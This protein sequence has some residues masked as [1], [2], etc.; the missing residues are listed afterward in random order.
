MKPILIAAAMMLG[1]M[2]LAV[3]QQKSDGEEK[4][5]VKS[6]T[7]LVQYLVTSRKGSNEEEVLRALDQGCA[8]AMVQRNL[9]VLE[10]IEADEFTFTTPD[11]TIMT[12]AQD[13]ETIRSGDIVYDSLTLEDVKVKVFGDAGVVTGRAL[14]K[15]RYK[16]F[17]IS[18][19]YRYTV[20][21]VKRQGRWQAVASQMT[22]ARGGM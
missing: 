3:G 8:Q 1:T 7:K 10:L 21:F 15:G 11:G 6:L 17:D 20:T 18:G 5:E 19:A 4:R 16:T 22:R 12:K 9:E 13:L 2:T 14:V